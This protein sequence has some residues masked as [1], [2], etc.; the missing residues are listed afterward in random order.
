MSMLEVGASLESWPHL[1]SEISEGS[2]RVV[3][4]ARKLLL[5]TRVYPSQRLRGDGESVKKEE[6][7]SPMMPRSRMIV[8]VHD[9]FPYQID[10]EKMVEAASSAASGGNSQ[11]WG[12]E[13][14][15]TGEI[16][17]SRSSHSKEE[18]FLDVGLEGTILAL[19]SVVE[20]LLEECSIQGYRAT[21][22]FDDGF[23]HNHLYFASVQ[24][25][26]KELK[27]LDTPV[28]RLWEVRRT[29][30][31]RRTHSS[32]QNQDDHYRLASSVVGRLGLENAKLYS[33]DHFA[34]IKGALVELERLRMINRE[35]A[36]DIRK[37]LVLDPT[38][39]V[40]ISIDSLHLRESEKLGMSVYL[41]EEVFNKLSQEP[42]VSGA[43]LTESFE[44]QLEDSFGFM[45]FSSRSS[46]FRDIVNASREVH[47]VWAK[48]NFHGIQVQPCSAG[49]FVAKRFQ[50][51]GDPSFLQ[52]LRRKFADLEVPLEGVPFFALRLHI[53]ELCSFPSMRREYTLNR[54]CNDD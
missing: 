40:G 7:S 28:E 47:R 41:D 5:D 26:G 17:V 16:V 33:P 43:K 18:E 46:D 2:G 42:N 53:N 24:I 25:A 39:P 50:Q 48:L 19:S 13:F 45:C 14:N 3:A 34:P 37:E 21:V 35:A 29:N 31:R 4:I 54:L 44:E 6:S 51:K 23:G 32:I 8:S 11:P 1:A 38:S 20:C 36:S 9:Q 52:S 27:D 12:I 30:R 22:S 10:I 15:Q 49:F